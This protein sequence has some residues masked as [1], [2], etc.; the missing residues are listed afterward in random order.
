MA[1]RR[2]QLFFTAAVAACSCWTSLAAD[3]YSAPRP[4]YTPP[5]RQT[6]TPPARSTYN[7]SASQP[8]SYSTGTTRTNTFNNRSV[9]SP[10]PA[11]TSSRPASNPYSYSATQKARLGAGKVNSAHVN[12]MGNRLSSAG[13]TKPAV[14]SGLVNRNAKRNTRPT[15]NLR[16]ARLRQTSAGPIKTPVGTGVSASANKHVQVGGRGPMTSSVNVNKAFTNA[17]NNTTPPVKTAGDNSN[18][19]PAATPHGAS[20]ASHLPAPTHR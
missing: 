7:S 9:A 16:Q 17:H 11:T 6:Y 20:I 12:G 13:S 3:K 19:K 10:R 1:T 18:G 2:S 4:T 8:R 5:P 14:K 15:P